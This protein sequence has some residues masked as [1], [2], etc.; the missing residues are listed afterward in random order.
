MARLPCV[1]QCT[2]MGRGL[3]LIYGDSMVTGIL[4]LSPLGFERLFLLFAV[5]S[6]S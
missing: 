5:L 1:H 2:S 3:T 4:Y 6:G